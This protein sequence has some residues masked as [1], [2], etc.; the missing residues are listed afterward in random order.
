MLAAWP[1]CWTGW[2]T[3]RADLAGT[4]AG[5]RRRGRRRRL[6]ATADPVAARPRPA[7]SRGCGPSSSGALGVAICADLI[8]PSLSWLVCGA[9]RQGCPGPL[10]WPGLVTRRGSPGC[11]NC[12]PAIRA[13]PR[14]PGATMR[15]GGP[16][17][18]RGQGRHDSP[19][20]P[21]ATSWSCWMPRLSAHAAPT[22]RRRGVLPAAAPDRELRR[23]APARL[24]A[25]AHARAAHAR[26]ADRPLPPRLPA[27]P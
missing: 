6:A 24:R 18:H 21:S 7:L 14:P 17:D 13:S 23:Q 8:R 16:A 20:S 5:Q 9:A 22:P 3:S 2:R 15:C 25:I 10:T 26:G 1:G 11:G 4:L 19:T 12:A 27:G